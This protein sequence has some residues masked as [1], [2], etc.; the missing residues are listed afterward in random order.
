MINLTADSTSMTLGL[1]ASNQLATVCLAFALCL[2]ACRKKPEP[3][4]ET[5]PLIEAA[6][7]DTSTAP[8]GAPPPQPVA[9][10]EPAPDFDK[11]SNEDKYWAEM[12]DSITSFVQD[13]VRNR[14]RMPK[15]AKDI[16]DMK[17]MSRVDVPPNYDLTIDQR[18][19]KV[20]I[21][22]KKK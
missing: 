2:T 13:H 9:S 14:G 6:Q 18:T 10:T 1:F 5:P 21:R 17:I 11:M 19:G 4:Q 20:A 15:T 22:K 12:A 8:D 7:P 3:A 16:T